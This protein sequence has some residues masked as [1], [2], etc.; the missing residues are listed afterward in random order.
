MFVDCSELC[1]RKPRP[2][3]LCRKVIKFPARI[4]PEACRCFFK[5]TKHHHLPTRAHKCS[6]KMHLFSLGQT[7]TFHSC[8]RTR[9]ED[10]LEHRGKY[11]KRP[12]GVNNS[13]KTLTDRT[14]ATIGHHRP[15]SLKAQRR[16]SVSILHQVLGNISPTRLKGQSLQTRLEPQVAV[17]GSA[18]FGCT[19]L[20][21]SDPKYFDLQQFQEKEM[22]SVSPNNG[23]HLD[24][25]VRNVWLIAVARADRCTARSSQVKLL[26]L[27]SSHPAEVFYRPPLQ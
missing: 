4:I 3:I 8:T 10:F 22:T 25:P 16:C 26:F 19:T 1:A 18:V 27:F 5:I 24:T 11:S 23:L 9:S 14:K 15:E 17:R 21:V 12:D 2:I 7:F 13:Q 6:H 20:H